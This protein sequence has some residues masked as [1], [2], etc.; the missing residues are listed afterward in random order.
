MECKLNKLWSNYFPLHVIW[1]FIF[2]SIHFIFGYGRIQN[3][4]CFLFSSDRGWKEVQTKD[5]SF[6]IQCKYLSLGMGI[7]NSYSPWRLTQ[8]LDVGLV[9]GEDL[10]PWFV[11]IH[12]LCDLICSA[13][14]DYI[15][16]LLF[17]FAA[18]NAF[19]NSVSFFLF[20]LCF[21]LSHSGNFLKDKEL[22]SLNACGQAD[23]W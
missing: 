5:I 16:T 13:S 2:L 21:F 19:N 14:T 4:S 17:S 7:E 10:L 22:V 3:V 12:E 8:C 11:A 23:I 9:A 15:S 20:W 18:F 6:S 1:K